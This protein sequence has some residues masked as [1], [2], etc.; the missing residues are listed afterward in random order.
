M[1]GMRDVAKHAG[2][3]L[4]TVSAVLNNTDKYVSAAIKQKVIKSAQELG[5]NLLTRKKFGQKTIAVVLPVIASA[6]FSNLFNGI[7][8]PISQDKNLLLFYNSD[9]S[10]EKEQAS[11]KILRKLSLAGIILDSVCPVDLEKDYLAW[12]KTEFINRG[13]PVLM[14]ERKI[15]DPLF[16]CIYINNFDCARTA[17]QHLIDKGHRKI[18]HISGNVLMHHSY[19][20]L[21][22]YKRALSDNDIAVDPELI[23][24]GDWS[25]QSGYTAMK[26]LIAKRDDFTGLFSANDQMAIGAMKVLRAYG[27]K[28]PQDCAV[29]G[30]DN[31]SVST[32]IDPSLTTIN[33]PIFKMGRLAAKLILDHCEGKI[34]KNKIE[35]QTTLIIRRSSDAAAANEWDLFG[36]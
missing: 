2:V 33:I 15:I 18:A 10:F 31:L 29:V 22:G 12:L 8:E 28:I 27:K 11:L 34:N 6:F 36:W 13:I 24:S 21:D 32:L 7:E 19:E 20:R 1:S 35:L 25:P 14:L 26:K 17:T 4:S 30:F 3:S 5:Y 16:Y 9:Y 23:Q